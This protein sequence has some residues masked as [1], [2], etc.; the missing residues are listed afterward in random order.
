MLKEAYFYNK[1]PDYIVE[2]KLCPHHCKLKAGQK[3]ICQVRYNNNGKLYTLNYANISALA[4]DP[5]EKKPLYHFYP[6]KMILSAGTYGCN[7]SCSFCQ[8]YGIAQE[9]KK[10]RFILP[11]DMVEICLDT[12]IENSIGL[13]FT[14][15]EPSIWYEYII[16]TAKILKEKGMQVVLISNGYIEMEP[17]EKLLPFIDAMNIDL[18]AFNNEF[19]T[20]NCKAKLDPVKN[21]IEKVASF[22]HLEVTNLIITD[23]NDTPAEIKELASYLATIN[24]DIP[25]H[26]SRYFP[27]YKFSNLP[28][29]IKIM[30]KSYEIA[31]EY[32]NFVYLGNMAKENN[33]YCKECGA[34]L[35]KRDNYNVEFIHWQNNKCLNCGADINYIVN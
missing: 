11:K 20:R 31:K 1:Y 3:G 13:A 24:P 32:L 26:L 16:E 34:T 6:G 19:Y 22:I 8:N 12:K 28:T 2:C 35:I 9:V 15:N 23:E 33:T 14:Y 25:L 27:A 29:P 21:V 7:L 10:G 18:K 17:L 4:L 5:M 30:E